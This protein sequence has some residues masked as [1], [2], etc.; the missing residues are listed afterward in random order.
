LVEIAVGL[1]DIAR[2]QA[3]IVAQERGLGLLHAETRPG[4][5]ASMS[6]SQYETESELNAALF[7]RHETV[8]S[9]ETSGARQS[10]RA[11]GDCQ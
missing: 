9:S 10:D 5:F 6:R 2:R 3:K 11:G 1:V 7:G 4:K 8:L